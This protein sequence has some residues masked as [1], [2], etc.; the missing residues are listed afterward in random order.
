MA[1]DGE[2]VVAMSM[3]EYV[4]MVEQMRSWK[5]K[6]LRNRT[7][8]NKA[9]EE[10]AELA[11]QVAALQRDQGFQVLKIQ[12]DDL[13]QEYAI[14][15]EQIE[16]LKG[17][18][19]RCSE[20]NASLN[21]AVA[22]GKDI[23]QQLHVH[24]AELRA[25]NTG[26]REDLEDVSEARL[27]SVKREAVLLGENERLEAELEQYRRHYLSMSSGS[28]FEDGDVAVVAGEDVEQ[29]PL[30]TDSDADVALGASPVSVVA[31]A[32]YFA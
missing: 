2:E 7:R 22:M 9:M 14:A 26:L 30:P 10:K 12:F 32:E 20:A 19:K 5:N 17:Q 21:A 1:K 28:H 3:A 11:G 13:A 18:Y 25:S 23:I 29:L 15:A 27:A 16:Q 6:A 8:F 4:Y 31:G 24:S